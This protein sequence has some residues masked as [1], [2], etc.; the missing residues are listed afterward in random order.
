MKT[1]PLL[2]DL[3]FSVSHRFCEKPASTFSHDALGTMIRW[4]YVG[5][6]CCRQHVSLRILYRKEKGRTHGPAFSDYVEMA[7][8]YLAGAG[9]AVGS[10]TGLSDSVRR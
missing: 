5:F 1:Y 6:S 8:L 7:T 4:D 2:F 10:G 9:A 3:S